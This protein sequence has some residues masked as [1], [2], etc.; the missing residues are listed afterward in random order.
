[1]IWDA[2]KEIDCFIFLIFGLIQRA[3]GVNNK[4][5]VFAEFYFKKNLFNQHFFQLIN[6]ITDFRDSLGIEYDSNN[7]ENLNDGLFAMKRK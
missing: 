6:F 1:M 5:D 7:S 4:D 3:E 2:P